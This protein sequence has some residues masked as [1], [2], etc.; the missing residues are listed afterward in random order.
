ML[1][2][3]IYYLLTAGGIS[4]LAYFIFK[5][6]ITKSFDFAIEKY[7]VELNKDLENY[8]Q[9]FLLDTEKFKADLNIISIEHNISFSKL[10]E[11]RAVVIKITYIKL[12]DLQNKLFNLT[13]MFQSSEWV[14]D[15]ERD[16]D[17][18]KSLDEFKDYFSINRI[19]LTKDV[20][21]KILNIITKSWDVI[22]EMSLTKDD[23][24]LEYNGGKI[25]I[26]Q[27]RELNKKVT[28]DINLA[29][30]ELEDNFRKLLGDK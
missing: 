15:V 17:A 23:A 21:D 3:I 5:T 26:Q 29:A 18:K 10:Q 8:K 30:N 20:C 19:F 28:N 27:W 7:K 25:F 6:A 1:Q 11:E 22:V 16:N 9:K 4:A 14:N 13:T 2:S 12:I 24:K